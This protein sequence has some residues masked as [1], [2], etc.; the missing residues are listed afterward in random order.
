MCLSEKIQQRYV[1]SSGFILQFSQ[2]L[3]FIEDERP[4]H[5]E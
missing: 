1:T 2:S 4:D 3:L 5:L